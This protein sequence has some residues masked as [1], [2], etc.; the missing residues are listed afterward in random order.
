MEKAPGV[1]SVVSGFI[2]GKLKDPS[3]DEVCSGVT[4]YYEAVEVLF[5][6][7]QVNFEQLAKLF[8]EIHDPTQWNH[9]GPDVGEQYRSAVFYMNDE[10][11]EI[12]EKLIGILKE[13]GYNVVTEVKPASA[14][15][16]AENKHQDY[17]KLK[18]TTPNCHVYTKR[19]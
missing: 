2:G 3:Y 19:F 12:T 14:F 11:K 18:G 9:Q 4:G 1:Y 7:A 10:Q 17:Y 8:F 6:P 15:Y 5:D 16:R 13:N